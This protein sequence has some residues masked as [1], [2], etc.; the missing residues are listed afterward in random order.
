MLLAAAGCLAGQ[1]GPPA[2]VF[3]GDSAHP[4]ASGEVWLVAH[5]WGYYPATLVATI[6]DGRLEPI[7]EPE[8]IELVEQAD[9]FRLLVA[10]SD[11]RKPPRGLRTTDRAYGD[12]E[13]GFF[14]EFPFVYLSDAIPKDRLGRDWPAVLNRMGR[15]TG[16]TA[17]T[18]A[19][20]GRR[21]VRLL[22]PDGRP[23]AGEVIAVDLF[24][25]YNNHCGRPGGVHVGTFRTDSGGLIRFDAPLVPLVL[26]LSYHDEANSGPAG[27][28][29][30]LKA[31]VITGS[32]ADVTLRKWWEL[33]RRPYVVTVRTRSGQPL[34]GA[35]LT[36]CWRHEVCGAVCGPIP[37]PVAVSDGAGLLRFEFFDLRAMETIS[38]LDPAEEERPLGV[39]ELREIMTTGRLT[40]TWQ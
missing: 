1:S 8:P 17:L 13:G 7:P 34:P 22:Y 31:G 29:F 18:L 33:P 9:D 15:V 3:L 21:S 27:F 36:G 26:H 35:R 20:P 38:V 28:S 10:V 11:R 39:S 40:F 37:I 30:V 4:A 23:L 19:R 12:T 2:R 14:A 6:R 5:R 16:G 24:A 25:T 32:E